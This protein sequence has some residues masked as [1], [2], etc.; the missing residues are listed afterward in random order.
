[1]GYTA[2]FMVYEYYHLRADFLVLIIS[3]PSTLDF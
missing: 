2:G 1:M 3:P